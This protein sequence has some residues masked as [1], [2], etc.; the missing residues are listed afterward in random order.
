MAHSE[1]WI[2]EAIPTNRTL[3]RLTPAET[4]LYDDLRSNRLGT[5]VRLEQEKIGFQRLLD[6]LN[7]L[8]RQEKPVVKP[9]GSAAP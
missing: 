1:H 7:E 4:A 3:S 5:S 9:Q 2:E 8:T 6:A